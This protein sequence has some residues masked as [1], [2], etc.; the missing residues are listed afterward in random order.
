[1]DW[2][3]WGLIHKEKKG[4]SLHHNIQT[5]SGAQPASCSMGYGGYCRRGKV[6]GE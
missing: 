6:A 1:M 5:G 4:F 2:T 3:I